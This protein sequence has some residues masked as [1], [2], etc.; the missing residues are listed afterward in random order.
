MR[1]QPYEDIFILIRLHREYIV[2]VE[3]GKKLLKFLIEL[4]V[5][6]F[7]CVA[8]SM[9]I[10]FLVSTASIVSLFY[11]FKR[12]VLQIRSEGSSSQVL[13]DVWK[14]KSYNSIFFCTQFIINAFFLG[15]IF[16]IA[17]FIVCYILSFKETMIYTWKFLTTRKIEFYLSFL[18]VIL[19]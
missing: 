12:I 14:F 16:S 18:P 6:I 17:L 7:P 5:P 13:K 9:S 1:S 15:Y 11:H 19:G 8:V 3:D 2:S 10:G 4:L